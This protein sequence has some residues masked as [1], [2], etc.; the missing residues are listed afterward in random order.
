MLL[1]GLL[2]MIALVGTGVAEI[3]EPT[4]DSVAADIST[5]EVPAIVDWIM[6]NL[7]GFII[8]GLAAFGVSL[9]IAWKLSRQAGEFL[10]AVANFGEGVGD[11]PTVKKEFLD[12]LALFKNANPIDTFRGITK[13]KKSIAKNSVS[14]PTIKK[15]W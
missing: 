7:W 4:I 15:H 2:V 3:I 1:V 8:G 11:W 14:E 9:A 5:P 12:I 13:A 6:N 10:I